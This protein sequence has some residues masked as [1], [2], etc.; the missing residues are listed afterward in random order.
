MIL[1]PVGRPCCYHV[2]NAS[3]TWPAHIHRVIRPRRYSTVIGLVSTVVRVDV[4]LFRLRLS[5]QYDC[6]PMT[7]QRVEAMRCHNRSLYKIHCVR[8]ER[9]TLANRYSNV[10]KLEAQVLYPRRRELTPPALP[11][12]HWLDRTS[13][14]P[15]VVTGTSSCSLAQPRGLPAF[16]WKHFKTLSPQSYELSAESNGKPS[17]FQNFS[18]TR[19]SSQMVW[20]GDT[21]QPTELTACAAPDVGGGRGEG[22][23]ATEHGVFVQGGR[24]LTQPFQ[25]LLE[26]HANNA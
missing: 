12:T 15:R 24:G 4:T 13:D 22:P 9:N 3:T 25:K 20:T 14:S 10:S 6:K 11:V 21:N 17:P 18:N 26:Q 7:C 1:R 5:F 8:D 23:G 16:P 2:L 19:A